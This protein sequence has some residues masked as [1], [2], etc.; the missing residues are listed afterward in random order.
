MS[1]KAQDRMAVTVPL[2]FAWRALASADRR[3]RISSSAVR[4]WI[5]CCVVGMAASPR[6]A[7]GPTASCRG[8]ARRSLPG[9]PGVAPPSSRPGGIGRQA[10]VV[11]GRP[12]AERAVWRRSAA[13][14]RCSPVHA[15]LRMPCFF[16]V[17]QRPSREGSTISLG[18][19]GVCVVAMRHTIF[20]G[21]RELKGAP[22]PAVSSVGP[23]R[24]S[25]SLPDAPPCPR[26][27]SPIP[28]ARGSGRL[29]SRVHF[30]APMAPCRSCRASQAGIPAFFTTHRTVRYEIRRVSEIACLETPSLARR[31]ISPSPLISLDARRALWYLDGTPGREPLRVRPLC[32]ER[33]VYGR[34]IGREADT[35]AGPPRP[36]AA[37]G[38]RPVQKSDRPR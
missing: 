35:R 36:A 24:K 37:P 19:L 16:P 8:P 4:E 26:W 15:R 3:R 28:V 10:T 23:R 5:S 31:Q 33:T 9:T 27:P 32:A 38:E 17:G 30:T 25:A 29:S 11:A 20:P 2:S 7:S 22:A 13:A 18:W 12:R 21:G 6:I 14:R 1:S 34:A